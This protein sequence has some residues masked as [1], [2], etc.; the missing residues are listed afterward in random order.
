M[1]FFCTGATLDEVPKEGEGMKMNGSAAV[2]VASSKEE[3]IEILSKDIYATS[4]VW[5]LKN[6]SSISILSCEISC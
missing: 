5:D 6:V 4:E 3:I 1:L 2:V